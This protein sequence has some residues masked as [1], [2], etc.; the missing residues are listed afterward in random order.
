VSDA[1][2][3]YSVIQFSPDPARAEAVDV[4]VLLFCPARGFIAAK[5][6]RD[7]QRVRRMF[8]EDG[9]ENDRLNA[10]KK[11][12]E[13]RVA[14]LEPAGLEDLERFIAS[15]GND[16]ILTPARSIRVTGDPAELLGELHEE[17]VGSVEHEKAGPKIPELDEAMRSPKLAERIQFDQHVEV[18]RFGRWLQV[19]YAYQNGTFNLI[20]PQV[21]KSSP[22]ER[23][24]YLAMSGRVIREYGDPE[25]GEQQLIVVSDV[26][27]RAHRDELRET[28]GNVFDEENV[29]NVWRDELPRFIEE[30]EAE[31]D[32][33][34]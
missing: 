31:L 12:M 19:P 21:F 29:R 6:R 1:K 24:S 7:N 26:A 2:G 10:A 8:G 20:K 33:H 34:P 5:T 11:S 9:F 23:A 27:N 13:R 18:P 4:G 14:G 17:L 22:I 25:H 15:R 3:Y 30:V 32:A 28:I 16:I